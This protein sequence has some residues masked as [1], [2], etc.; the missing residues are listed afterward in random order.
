MRLT[1]PR[2]GAAATGEPMQDPMTKTFAPERGEI[3]PTFAARREKHFP[4]VI[5]TL[6]AV[7][8]GRPDFDAFIGRV[9]AVL[10]RA[11]DRRPGE[12][13]ALDAMRAEENFRFSRPEMIGYTAYTDRFAGD[14]NGVVAKIPHLKALGVGYLHLLPLLKP[15]AGDNDGGYAV[16]DHYQTD[17]R[18]GSMADLARL[19]G[20]LRAEGISLCLDFV[21]NHVADDHPWAERAKGGDARHRRFFHLY[22]DRAAP[23]AFERSLGAVFGE[24]APGNFTYVD[25]LGAWAWT[26]FHP[27]QWDLNYA[28]PDV[29]EGMLEALLF[30]ANQGA[31]IFRLDAAPYLWKRMGGPSRNEPEVFSLL[32][33]FKA[34]LA[35]AAPAVALKAEAIEPARS[36]SRYL[37]SGRGGGGC[38]LAYNTTLMNGSWAALALGDARPLVRTLNAAPRLEAGAAF[39]TYVRCHDD[40]GWHVFAADLAAAGEKDADAIAAKAREFYANGEGFAEGALFQTHGVCG[41]TASLCGLGRARRSGDKAAEA[42]AIRRMLALYALAYGYGGAP[43]INM[44]DE[45]GLLNDPQYREDARY[46]GDGRWLHRGAMPWAVI[47]TGDAAARALTE[48]LQMLAAARR[49]SP[50]LKGSQARARASADGAIALLVHGE[51]AL[52]VAANVT[53]SQAAFDL[54]GEG[55][56]RDRLSGRL[57]SAGRATL[58]AYGSVWLTRER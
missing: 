21:L 31:E 49:Q 16:A 17:P 30:L 56:W 6:G 53:A 9:D 55:V 50:A 14:L 36:L 7:Y 5:E 32:S 54:E 51:G 20:A 41:S 35:I 37:R 48:G 12:L 3:G 45:A 8:G 1:P 18:L 27:Y 52:I 29:F 34:L 25:A 58:P 26:T 2:R 38:D 23:D 22:R 46:D 4:R 44:G 42:L 47:E 57:F 11:A 28:N 24:T 13:K 15:R 19:A 10:R 40:I 33:A 43:L 39:A